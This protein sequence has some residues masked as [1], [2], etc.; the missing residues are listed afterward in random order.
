MPWLPQRDESVARAIQDK[1]DALHRVALRLER[2]PDAAADLVQET[3]LR[4]WRH[5]DR[6]QTAELG[7][8]LFC[9]L[10]HVWVDRWRHARR[11]PAFAELPAEVE[12]EAEADTAAP[13]MPQDAAD[14]A[15]LEQHF[16]DEVLAALDELPEQERLALLFH[17]FGDMS[18]REISLALECPLGTVM[19]R[20]H[21]AR[22]RL[23]A[24]LAAYARSRGIVSANDDSR[25]SDERRG[26]AEA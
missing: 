5:R 11:G 4:A 18:Y 19:S 15:R 7:S 14:R 1:L 20:L 13:L 2:K 26:H 23:R 24:R 25:P 6:T 16:D 17:A 8:W 3:C 9:I 12:D 21:R 10:H 22:S